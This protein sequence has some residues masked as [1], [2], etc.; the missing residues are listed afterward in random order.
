MILIR[1]FFFAVLSL[2]PIA[3]F[4]EPIHLLNVSYDPTREFYQQFN[5]T[6]A[7][8]YKAK[9]GK[10]VLID[11]SHGGSSFRELV[12]QQFSIIIDRYDPDRRSNL[13][14]EQLPRHDI[15]RRLTIA[16]FFADLQL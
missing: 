16:Y 10:E 4:G 15:A 3:G 12:N 6:F 14:R 13:F 7:K 11:Q 9:T 2:L 8:Q 1:N 5:E